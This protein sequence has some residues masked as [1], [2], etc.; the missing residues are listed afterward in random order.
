MRTGFR[1]TRSPVRATT[2]GLAISLLAAR[3]EPYA[4]STL[5]LDGIITG[6]NSGLGNLTFSGSGHT[7]LYGANNIN[8]TS[9]EL[10]N[11]TVEVNGS[12]ITS[13]PL[14][15][16]GSATLSGIGTVTST[17]G[18]PYKR[19][20]VDG[21]IAPGTATTP[22]TLTLGPSLRFYFG[23]DSVNIRLNGEEEG[24]YD[25]V[26]VLGGVSLNDAILDVELGFMPTVGQTFTILENDESD[27]IIGTFSGLDEGSLLAIG[28]TVFRIS[29]IGGTGNDVVLTTVPASYP[30]IASAGGPYKGTEG[31][32]VTFNASGS[33]DPDGDELQ[34]RWD[35]D[36]DGTWD[37]L[38]SI[39]PTAT[40]LW[41]DDSI[42][43]TTVE[44]T[45]G[46]TRSADTAS[47]TV[48]NVAPTLTDIAGLTIDPIPVGSNI[49][50]SA[51]FADPGVADTHTATWDWGDGSVTVV[52]GATSLLSG[53]H[54]YQTP[55]VFTVKL[56]I[57]DDDGGENESIFQYVV[58]CDPTAGFVTGGGWIDSPEGAYAADPTVT[59]KA[60][61]G[62]VSKYK[63]G[64]DTPTGHTSFQ[65]NMADL[66]FQSVDYHTTT[67]NLRYSKMY[68]STN[69]PS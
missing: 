61:F 58:I 60:N 57:A 49:D 45:D 26:K 48:D 55:G 53:S 28:S 6:D 42:G 36:G 4:G 1:V 56:R 67:V 7:V 15:V 63:K 23:D 20:I 52:D 17:Y 47:V 64:A 9:I 51:V 69:S 18:D 33:S 5:Q 13:A 3:I 59:G 54:T 16:G 2:S 24:Q 38:W 41:S 25:Q 65:F 44:V 12:L 66:T 62:F 46:F 32:S 31:T 19:V 11:G 50:A 29:Y 43:I 68:Y 34:Y 37:T 27:P 39:D 21:Q 22:G 40:Y 30:P 10:A 8:Y 14:V 35:F